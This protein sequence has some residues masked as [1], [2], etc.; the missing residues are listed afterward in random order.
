M[1]G[2]VFLTLEKEVARRGRA[3]TDLVVHILTSQFQFPTEREVFGSHDG[4]E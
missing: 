2:K 1:Y 3:S 4:D